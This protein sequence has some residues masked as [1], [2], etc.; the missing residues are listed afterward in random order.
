MTT[1]SSKKT[2]SE[3]GRVCGESHP[4]ATLTDAEVELIRLCKED[5]MSLSDIAEKFEISRGTAQS[6]CNY[7]RRATT[8]DR[9]R[10]VD[11]DAMFVTAKINLSVQHEPRR[12]EVLGRLALVHGS[13][14]AAIRH[15]IDTID[16]TGGA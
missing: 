11:A 4:H 13:I 5:G 10:G 3:A 9:I 2:L 12:L 8:P 7:T 16:Q 1:A 15:M 14:A 6:L